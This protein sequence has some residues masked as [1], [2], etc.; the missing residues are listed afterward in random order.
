MAPAAKAITTTVARLTSSRCLSESDAAAGRTTSST[1]AVAAVSNCE[2]TVLITAARTPATTMP[3]I[4][5][6]SSSPAKAMNTVSGSSRP[7]APK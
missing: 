3:A 2:S 1:R 4:H 6:A 5:G 7:A